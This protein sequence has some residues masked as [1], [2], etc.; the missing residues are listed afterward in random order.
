MTDRLAAT[1]EGIARA[2][3]LLADG[4]VVAF[5]TDTVYGVGVATTRPDRLEAL[6]T[7]SGGRRRSGSPSSCPTWTRPSTPAGWRTRLRAGSASASG[8]APCRWSCRPPM[9]RRRPSEP[10]T[11]PWHS[12]YPRG[13]AALHLEREPLRSAG[14]A[15]GGRRAHRLRDPAGRARGG[16]GRRPRPRR[17]RLYGTR[18][19]GL[20]GSHPARR[21]DHSIS[22]GGDRRAS[23][24]HQGLALLGRSCPRWQRATKPAGLVAPSARIGHA[25][26]AMRQ[27]GVDPMARPCT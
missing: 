12:T 19:V 6:F 1:A 26:G 23:L 11:I 9:A 18:P 22:A 5:P 4:E 17:H 16:R 7:S 21:T 27:K 3:S 10:P 8:P 2:A 15:R 25:T 24:M 14:D 13:G 20:P